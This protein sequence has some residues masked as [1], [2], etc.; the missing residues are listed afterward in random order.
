MERSTKVPTIM[1][2]SF[3]LLQNPRKLAVFD[4]LCRAG[5]KVATKD[6][7]IAFQKE[8]LGETIGYIA[9]TLRELEDINLAKYVGE[10]TRT[11]SREGDWKQT[12]KCYEATDHGLYIHVLCK[13]YDSDR[14]L[15]NIG[16]TLD[17]KRVVESF[18]K[19][20]KD[21]LAFMLK[22]FRDVY[23]LGAVMISIHYQKHES[24]TS[25][26]LSRCVDG[27]LSKNEVEKLLG[28]YAGPDGLVVATSP[29]R[30]ILDRGFIRLAEL[31]AGK[32]RVRRWLSRASYSLTP[33]GKKIVLSL[34][35]EFHPTEL[36]V[37]EEYLRPEKVEADDGVLGRAI[38]ERVVILAVLVGVPVYSWSDLFR[39]L[40]YAPSDTVG[41]AVDLVMFFGTFF[42]LIF[43]VLLRLPNLLTRIA[44]WRKLRKEQSRP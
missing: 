18:A 20:Q 29:E 33:E 41:I 5:R 35:D 21:E 44:Y 32:N 22:R 15:A 9:T 28:D 19:L 37:N 14:P 38:V 40:N 34:L 2:Q 24:A 31:L 10:A 4:Y 25:D 26:W 6:V 3:S 11:Q 30:S 17:P 12:F 27:R 7:E 39:K 23:L 36:G 16:G 8:G 1:Y 13:S 42:A 43:F